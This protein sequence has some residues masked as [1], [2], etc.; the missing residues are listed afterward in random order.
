MALTAL[1]PVSSYRDADHRVL[2]KH[3]YAS[4]TPLTHISLFFQLRGYFSYFATQSQF[5][6]LLLGGS[7]QAAASLL[8]KC[9]SNSTKTS[10]KKLNQWQGQCLRSYRGARLM[11]LGRRKHLQQLEPAVIPQAL[12]DLTLKFSLRMQD[13]TSGT[14]FVCD[15]RTEKESKIRKFFQ[16]FVSQELYLTK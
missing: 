12:T 10:F 16:Y 9:D 2:I 15:S 7:C 6:T 13:L 14:W 8:Q 11:H 3:D 5:C 1:Q 4:Y